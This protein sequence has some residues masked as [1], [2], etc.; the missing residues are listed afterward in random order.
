MFIFNHANM[1]QYRYESDNT[2][3]T[4]AKYLCINS[5][6]LQQTFV[7]ALMYTYCAGVSTSGAPFKSPGRVGDSPL[8]G[9]G[10]YAD[11]TVSYAAL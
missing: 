6:I 5:V 4:F 1:I 7:C 9:C 2:E 8:P 3:L 11:H 10:L